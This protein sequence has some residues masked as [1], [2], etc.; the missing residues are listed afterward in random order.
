MILLPTREEK[1]KPP[2]KELKSLQGCGAFA[3][4]WL[5]GEEIWAINTSSN[6]WQPPMTMLGRKRSAV[7]SSSSLLFRSSTEAS[8]SSNTGPTSGYATCPAGTH[9]SQRQVS[10]ATTLSPSYITLLFLFMDT[11]I[12][13]LIYI[14]YFSLL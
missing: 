10:R 1:N 9:G 6:G 3:L 13:T 2:R 12:R 5:Q 4:L 14:M 8:E 7:T 11:L